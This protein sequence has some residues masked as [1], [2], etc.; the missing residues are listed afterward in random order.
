VI[1]VL[2]LLAVMSRILRWRASLSGHDPRPQDGPPPKV[3]Q[4]WNSTGTRI[5]WRLA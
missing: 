5:V 4:E 1:G 3:T 2:E